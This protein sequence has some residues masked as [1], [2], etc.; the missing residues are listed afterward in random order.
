MILI[1]YKFTAQQHEL[2][3]YLTSQSLD[4]TFNPET[5]DN[6]EYPNRQSYAVVPRLPSSYTAALKYGPEYDVFY[7]Y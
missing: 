3:K 4:T 5:A 7:G 1:C 2:V 6:D